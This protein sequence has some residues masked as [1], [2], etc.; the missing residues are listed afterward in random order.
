MGMAREPKK[1]LNNKYAAFVR[2][3]QGVGKKKGVRRSWGEKGGRLS[4]RGGKRK[5]PPLRNHGENKIF[6]AGGGKKTKSGGTQS[7]KLTGH[8]G[9]V[10]RPQCDAESKQTSTTS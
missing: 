9:G 2:A 3:I 1:K 6:T 5:N 8:S 4:P 10:K 7:A